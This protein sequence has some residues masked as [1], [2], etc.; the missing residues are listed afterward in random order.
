MV[1][2]VISPACGPGSLQL[3]LLTFLAAACPPMLPS[4]TPTTFAFLLSISNIDYLSMV[5]LLSYGWTLDCLHG[6]FGL[7]VF[8]SPK[9]ELA[10]PL[11]FDISLGL[12]QRHICL[13]L[14]D[15][16]SEVLLL[17]QLSQVDT[18]S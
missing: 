17:I 8:P 13:T 14:W 6:C 1:T 12:P 11:T 10:V 2:A 9:Y 4:W 5:C 18:A 15:V 7:F 16:R 3:T